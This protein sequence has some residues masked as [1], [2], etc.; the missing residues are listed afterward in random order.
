MAEAQTPARPE[1]SLDDKYLQAQGRVF[2]TGHQALVRLPLQQRARDLAAGKNTAG[3]I[4]GYRGSPMGRYDLELWRVDALL[5][6]HHIVFRPG[7]NEELAATAVWGSQFVG[8]QAQA[9]YDGVFAIWYGKGPGVDR[10]ADA[11]KHANHGGSS[12]WGGVLAIGGDDHGCKSSTIPNFSDPV[13]IACGMPLLYPA[14]TQELLDF[15]LHGLAMSRF[16]GCWV[17]MKVVTD[18]VEGSGSVRVGP[19]LPAIVLPPPGLLPPGG[20][21]LRPLE[22]GL[23]QEARLYQHKLPAALAYCRAN[24][25][26]R[27]D[28]EVVGA[29]IG[30]LAAGK[31]WQDVQ[32]ALQMLGIDRQRAQALGIRTAKIG[33]VWPLDPDFV[34]EFAR[35]LEQLL[36]IEEKRPLLEEQVK[37]ALYDGPPDAKPRVIG[38]YDGSNVW[39]GQPGRPL[40]SMVGELSPPQIAQLIASSLAPYHPEF[41]TPDAPCDAAPSAL[42]PGPVRMPGFCSGCPHNRSTRLPDGSRALAGIGCHTMAVL[43]DPARTHSIS[44]MGGEG[45]MWLGQQ[46][47]TDERH[48]FANMG[49][50]TFFHSGFLAIRQAVAANLP[51][52]YKLLVNGFVAMTGGQ[53]IEGHLSVRQTVQGLLAEGVGKITVVTDQP[54]DYPAGALPAG[55]PVRPRSQLDAVQ[56][57]LRDYPGVSVIVYQQPCATERRRLRKRGQTPDPEQRSFINAAVCEGCGDCSQVSGCMSIEPLETEFGRKR[58][59]NQASCNKD[60]SCVEGFCPS[61]VTLKGARLRQPET[62]AMAHAVPAL[63]APELP[64]AQ[65][66]YAVLISGIGGTG[67]VTMGQILGVAAHIDGLQVSV[68]DVTGLAQKYGAVLSHVMISSDP[69]DLHATRIAAGMAQALIG[70]DLV[71]SAGDEVLSKLRPGVTRAVVNTDLIPTVDFSRNPDWALDPKALLGRLSSRLGERCT[72][73]D[74]S[75]LATALL[76]DPLTAN[77]FLLGVA[78]QSGLLPLSLAALQRAIELN[79]V[80]VPGNL[81]SF[82]WGRAAVC[83]PDAVARASRRGNDAPGDH[84]APRDLASLLERRADFLTQYQNRAYA[85]R[86]QYLVQR[87]AQAE[88]ALGCGD[89]LAKA[90][91]HSYFK[92][93]ASKDVFEVARLYSAPQFRADLQR[94]F[95]G[96]LKLRFHLG[97]WPFAKRDA[98]TGQVTKGEVGPWLLPVFR[99]LTGLRRWRNTWLDPLRHTAERTLDRALLAEFESDVQRL[100]TDLSPARHAASVALAA[101]PLKVRGFGHVRQANAARMAVERATLWQQLAEQSTAAPQAQPGL[102]V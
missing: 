10:S 60:Y 7:V 53:P 61:F 58:R 68:L 13:F 77:M 24:G 56:R 37:A 99:L 52:T 66:G 101:L 91:A 9:R 49:D 84:A 31:A 62:G 88:D 70:C 74:A 5:K 85:Q 80:Q 19:L 22:H 12:A 67:V 11:I 8:A 83:D 97:L 92:L 38:K 36:V 6:Q 63:V 96:D 30:I 89:E 23:L 54:G 45:A 79:G 3:Y 29:R 57:E 81:A 26:N 69:A 20:L 34:Q 1:I 90:V 40:M 25:L 82:A 71:V 64:A 16:S 98:A 2:M 93:L 27:I 32:Q 76:G 94:Q 51:I 14:D 15:G 42:G 59:I 78:W 46:P 48:V 28:A 17:G 73:I 39:S 47:F 4:S 18:V 21:Y 72:P 87:V 95:E 86:Y 33:M 44:Q 55:V 41:A 35:A 65:G 43:V 100:L 50:G 75:R 102:R